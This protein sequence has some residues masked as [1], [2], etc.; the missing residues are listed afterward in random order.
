MVK[1]I[2]CIG[3]AL[4][5]SSVLFVG[6]GTNV[7]PGGGGGG[8]DPTKT[9]LRVATYDGG[10]GDAWLNSAADRFEELYKDAH[11]E[12]GKTGVTVKVLANKTYNGETI[13]DSLKNDDVDVYFTETVNYY[14]HVNRGNFADI[15]DIVKDETLEEFG[16]EGTILDKIDK[17]F[18]EYLSIDGKYY[19]LPFYEGIYGIIY[20]KD[21]FLSNKLYFA[22]SGSLEGDKADDLGFIRSASDTKSA[23]PDGKLETYDDGLPATYAQFEAL[24]EHIRLDTSVIPFSYAG[25]TREY[26]SRAMTTLWAD[27]EGYDQMRLNF[28]LTG[29]AT[30]LVT[31]ISSDGTVQT[32]TKNITTANAYELQRQSGKYYALSFLKDIVL[33]DPGNYKTNGSTHLDAQSNFIKGNLDPNKFDVYAMHFDGAWWENEADSSFT[34]LEQLYGDDAARKK[35]NFGFM[36][37]PKTD[38]DQVGKGVTLISQ[39]NSLCFIRSTTD[40]LELAKTFLQFIHTNQELSAF[41]AGV[42][43]TRPFSY[44]MEEED[45]ALMSPYA[46]S[47]YLICSDAK[48]VQPYSKNE[49]FI[50]NQTYF[51]LESWAWQSSVNGYVK[52]NPFSAFLDGDV[53]TAADYFNGQ[54]AYYKENWNFS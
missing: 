12:E 38:A 2:V 14:D 25:S 15:T 27:A 13:L 42:S 8:E 48:I 53:K 37:I 39:A 19:A 45:E 6:C 4:V 16:E 50:K 35:M 23:G 10:V 41:T 30:D 5:L 47:L 54:Y 52:Y 26:P 33:G 49:V 29:T 36:P 20:N 11:F 9:T 22:H 28:Q 3:M 31:G 7:A 40:K 34:S 43:M 21:V 46:E 1:K 17:D 18:A 51:S 44:T 24:V 32:E